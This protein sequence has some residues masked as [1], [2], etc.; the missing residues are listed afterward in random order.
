MQDPAITHLV[1]V[2]LGDLRTRYSGGLERFLTLLASDAGRKSFEE[3]RSDKVTVVFLDA[4]KALAETSTAGVSADQT[5]ITMAFGV[6]S[7]MNL[8]VRLLEDPTRVFPGI[9]DGE[10][11]LRERQ[12][13]PDTVHETYDQ[14]DPDI[15][16]LSADKE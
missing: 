1:N 4:L 12:A 10:Q 7:G 9:F 5:G 13:A 11:S 6:S 3:W 15:P 2:L 14:P 16:G 8:A